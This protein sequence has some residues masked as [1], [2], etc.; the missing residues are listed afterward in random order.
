MLSRLLHWQCGD[1]S[2]AACLWV[3][4]SIPGLGRQIFPCTSPSRPPSRLPRQRPFSHLPTCPQNRVVNLTMGTGDAAV[5]YQFAVD[6]G[7]SLLEVSCQSSAAKANWG[8]KALSSSFVLMPAQTISSAAACAATG[9]DCFVTGASG[10]PGVC[11]FSQG[12]RPCYAWIDSKM[13]WGRMA[14]LENQ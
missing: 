11:Y 10:Q 3:C 6:T 8:G 9:I 1:D 7:S 13:Q 14:A 12:V 5:A 2:S 4:G